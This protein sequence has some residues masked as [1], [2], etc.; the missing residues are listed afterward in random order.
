MKIRRQLMLSQTALTL[1]AILVLIIPIF[2]SQ[3]NSLKK[4]ITQVSELQVE[5]VNDQIANFLENPQRT[6]DTVVAY[7]ENL[8]E[9]IVPASLNDDQAIMGAVKLAIDACM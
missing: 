6:I 7:M 4:Q 5:N 8:D 9:Y 1:F 3:K 2:L